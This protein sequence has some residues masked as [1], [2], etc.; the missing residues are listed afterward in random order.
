M[1]AGTLT[2]TVGD[3]I[4]VPPQPPSSSTS[5]S[6]PPS[7]ALTLTGQCRAPLWRITLVA[8]SRTAQA[9]RLHVWVD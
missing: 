2:G 3:A 9:N 7:G 4:A 1:A 6:A 5:T 8:P